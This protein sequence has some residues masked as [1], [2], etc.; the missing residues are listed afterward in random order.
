[1]QHADLTRQCHAHD[2]KAE[3]G[4]PQGNLRGDHEAH[5]TVPLRI[6]RSAIT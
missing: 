4:N 3:H 6:G 1:M 2:T 5:S